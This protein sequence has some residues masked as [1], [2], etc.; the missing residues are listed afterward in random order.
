MMLILNATE[1]SVWFSP[2]GFVKY[3][4]PVEVSKVQVFLGESLYAVPFAAKEMG[5][6]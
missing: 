2:W 3:Y 1:A 6:I 4:I 5:L